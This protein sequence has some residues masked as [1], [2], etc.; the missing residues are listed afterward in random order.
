MPRRSESGNTGLPIAPLVATRASLTRLSAS[1]R[2]STGTLCSQLD[3]HRDL[4]YFFEL[5]RLVTDDC[6]PDTR[7]QGRTIWLDTVPRD[8]PQS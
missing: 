5:C 8:A 6:R 1:S 4:T 2:R 7:S 3:D